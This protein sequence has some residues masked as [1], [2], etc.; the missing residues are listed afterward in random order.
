MTNIL[1][2]IDA[3]VGQRNQ[4]TDLGACTRLV[5]VTAVSSRP[6]GL[7]RMYC[8]A[9]TLNWT[10]EAL[11]DRPDVAIH[12]PAPTGLPGAPET[13]VV[14][15]LD[16]IKRVGNMLVAE[17]LAPDGSRSQFAISFRKKRVT[18]IQ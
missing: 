16:N 13:T 3:P 18:I 4:H 2:L 10:G 5:E 14:V 7:A 11:E 8:G 12:Y 17:G 15:K 6:D 9:A 1:A